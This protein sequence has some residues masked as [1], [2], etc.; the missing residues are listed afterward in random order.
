MSRINK[1]KGRQK[2]RE[3]VTKELQKAWKT[4]NKMTT[5]NS[6]PLT[7]TINANGLNSPMERHRVTGMEKKIIQCAHSRQ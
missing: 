5:V 7:T 2:E 3:H 4:I 6:Y 1:K